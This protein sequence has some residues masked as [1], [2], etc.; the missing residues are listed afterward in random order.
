[1]ALQQSMKQY[2][3]KFVQRLGLEGCDQI[4]ASSN[5]SA[6]QLEYPSSLPIYS[7]FLWYH[8][9]A[10][11]FHWHSTRPWNLVLSQTALLALI[12]TP[13]TTDW[14]RQSEAIHLLV[15]IL[16]H[17]L[18]HRFSL[19]PFD[20][21]IPKAFNPFILIYFENVLPSSIHWIDLNFLVLK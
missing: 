18:P 16:A 12:F 10:V 11:A 3:Q 19:Q 2:Y 4:L 7:I 20:L 9:P 21:Q 17:H 13:Q 6:I 1:M 5:P 14:P 8:W 15:K